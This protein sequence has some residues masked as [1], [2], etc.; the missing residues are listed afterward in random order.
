MPHDLYFVFAE[1]KFQISQQ[2]TTFAYESMLP[3]VAEM[4][5]EWS[6]VANQVFT[7]HDHYMRVAILGML[8]VKLPHVFVAR[9]ILPNP[10][11]VHKSYV[12][13]LVTVRLVQARG[14]R[15]ATAVC[16]CRSILCRCGV[17]D[18]RG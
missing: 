12:L 17:C 13:C 10:N 9:S 2:V 14:R 16:A 6:V 11:M 3:L 1:S 5:N 8:L 15:N 4:D 18:L 7:T